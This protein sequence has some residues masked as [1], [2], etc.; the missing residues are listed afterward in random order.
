MHVSLK[1]TANQLFEATDMTRV[2]GITLWALLAVVKNRPEELVRL[3]DVLTYFMQT[4]EQG[5]ATDPT[6]LLGVIPVSVYIDTYHL[7]RRLLR[8]MS[9]LGIIATSKQISFRRM[10][11]WIHLQTAI[12]TGRIYVQMTTTTSFEGIAA[13]AF[14][15]DFQTFLA[16]C[17]IEQK[18]L[19]CNA[20]HLFTM[21]LG[22]V[23]D[24][25][26]HD[27][28]W[29]LLCDLKQLALV[30]TQSFDSFV[31]SVNVSTNTRQALMRQKLGMQIYGLFPCVLYKHCTNDRRHSR[32]LS[33]AMNLASAA[34]SYHQ[35]ALVQSGWVGDH[36]YDAIT[37]V[38]L[39]TA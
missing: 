2:A 4:W 30:F 32:W 38:D 27:A 34:L 10:Y 19:E 37:F 20:I 36:A 31:T 9:L 35:S 25:H 21:P 3:D 7:V 1:E 8:L 12:M 13:I 33:N 22:T 16:A 6:A 24:T 17:L 29:K 14:K 28:V 11:D 26:H 39:L 5:A 15:Q 23:T 18:R